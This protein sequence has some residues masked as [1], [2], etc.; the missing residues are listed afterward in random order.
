MITLTLQLVTRADAYRDPEGFLS[1][2][3]SFLAA[4]ASRAPEPKLNIWERPST[5]KSPLPVDLQQGIV[6]MAVSMLVDGVSVH[7]G[8]IVLLKGRK[9]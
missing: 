6:R 4:L 8:D 7:Q 2:E 5:G 9:G 3:R 1:E